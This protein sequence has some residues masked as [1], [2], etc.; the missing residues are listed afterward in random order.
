MASVHRANGTGPRSSPKN[1][2]IRRACANPMRAVG[3]AVATL[4]VFAYVPASEAR[5]AA[6][7]SPGDS[8]EDPGYMP[9]GH[10]VL[11]VLEPGQS[12][13][14]SDETYPDH[15]PAPGATKEN[16]A[17]NIVASYWQ[18]VSTDADLYFHDPRCHGPFCASTHHPGPLDACETTDCCGFT[19][20]VRYHA[21]ASGGSEPV[22]YAFAFCGA[23][24]I[25]NTP[26]G[27][28]CLPL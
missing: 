19:L 15:W 18:L 6:L 1:R 16:G 3:W 21:S 12:H 26:L 24:G 11:G 13:W 7:P 5:Q 14:Y 10:A 17:A 25:V 27:A 22:A 23:G 28:L 2:F 9:L 4:L 8:C 20:E